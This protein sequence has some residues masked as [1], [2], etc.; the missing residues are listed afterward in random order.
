MNIINQRRFRPDIDFQRAGT[1]QNFGSRLRGMRSIRGGSRAGTPG[2]SCQERSIGAEWQ[3]ARNQ[4]VARVTEF[5][6]V[7]SRRLAYTGVAKKASNRPR[8]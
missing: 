2:G 5:Y 1:E 4:L 3:A 7:G 8:R 6:R